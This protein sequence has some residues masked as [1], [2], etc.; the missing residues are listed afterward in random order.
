[1]STVF[2]KLCKEKDWF[3]KEKKYSCK[4]ATTFRA[5]YD[6]RELLINRTRIQL[7]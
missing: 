6:Y 7:I 5:S 3:G 1:M 2:L 4:D